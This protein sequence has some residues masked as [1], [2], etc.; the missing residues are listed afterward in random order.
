MTAGALKRPKPAPDDGGDEIEAS[1][2]PLMDH[3]V[4]LRTRLVRSLIVLVTFFIAAWFVSEPAV[5][6]LLVPFN[7]AAEANGRDASQVFF[8]GPLELLFIKL[9]ICFLLGLAASFPFIAYQAY[10]F[11]APGLYRNE[12]SAALPFLFVMPVLFVAGGALVYYTVLPLFMGLA[13]DQ[14]ITNG[15]T[16]VG[17]LPRVKEY[18]DL[19]ISLLT[20]FGVAFQLP[21]VI[22]LLAKADLIS[23]AGLRKTRKYAFVVILIV[24]AVMTPPDPFSQF[25]LGIP[26]YLLY[27]ISILAATLIERARRREDA[28]REAEERAEAQGAA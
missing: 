5:R 6:F 11:V 26:L 1:R 21:V 7:V 19:A 15:T 14:E 4:E 10:A 23:A 16:T 8:T 25:V 22:S 13:F 20:A 9:K 27:E 17:Y 2:A 12:R 3:L 18:Y 28:R 24:A